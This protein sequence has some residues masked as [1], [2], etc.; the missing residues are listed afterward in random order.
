MLRWIKGKDSAISLYK[1]VADI[2]CRQTRSSFVKWLVFCYFKE[3]EFGVRE[4]LLFRFRSFNEILYVRGKSIFGKRA[5]T[6]ISV[7]YCHFLPQAK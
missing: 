2:V 7:N 5:S 6:I 1:D 4:V 3:V